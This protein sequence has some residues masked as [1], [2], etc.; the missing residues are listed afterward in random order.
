MHHALTHDAQNVSVEGMSGK[1]VGWHA[2]LGWETR[3]N[4]EAW[5]IGWEGTWEV[6]WQFICRSSPMHPHSLPQS[7]ARRLLLFNSTCSGCTTRKCLVRAS[8]LLNVFSS[9]QSGQ[10]TLSLRA[11]WMVSSCRVRSYGR[12]KMVLHGLPVDGLIL[13]HCKNQLAFTLAK[14]KVAYL[15]L[16]TWRG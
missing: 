10:W 2:Q 12:E 11:L 13:S 3:R 8:F 4:Q 16:S 5:G 1:A 7:C 6:W 9:V 14:P 15:F